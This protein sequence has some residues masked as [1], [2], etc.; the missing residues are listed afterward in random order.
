FGIKPVGDIKSVPISEIPN[1]DIL[2]AGFP[3]QPFSKAGKQEGIN[4][5][6]RGNLFDNVV[7]ILSA[8]RPKYFILENVPQLA[9]HNNTE[10]WELMDAKLKE[11]GYDVKI[12]QYS[13][14]EFG[15]PQHRKRIYIVGKLGENSLEKFEWIDQ[16]SSTTKTDIKTILDKRAKGARKLDVKRI[17]CIEVWQEFLDCLSPDEPLGFPI[18]SFEFG[19]T[20]PFQKATPFSTKDLSKYK[21]SFGK[22][23]S[24][25]SYLSTDLPSYARTEQN[26]FPTWKQNYIKRNRNLFEKYKKELKQVKRKISNLSIPSWQKLEWNCQENKRVISKHILQF[27]ASGLRVKKTNFAPSLVCASTQIP[28]I[29]WKNRYITKTEA[30]RLQSF[31]VDFVLPE[32]NTT[33]FKAL[34]N[35]VNV[36]II[37]LIAKELIKDTS[38]EKKHKNGIKRNISKAKQHNYANL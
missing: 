28:I 9:K 27:R 24:G 38:K 1:F 26:Q 16:Y 5:K 7:D 3:C 12:E 19:A 30:L 18:W 4:D 33:A 35:A 6:V 37:H 11:I 21:G 25:Q 14:H 34:G 22:S 29:G 23:L 32:N 15:I 17:E 36:Q 10:T 13:P 8:K 31:P 20:Y 2:C